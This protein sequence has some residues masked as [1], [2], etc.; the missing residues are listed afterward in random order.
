[1]DNL[2]AVIKKFGDDVVRLSK[3]NL[4]SN[5]YGRHKK[6]NTTKTLSNS[7][8]HQISDNTISF[9]FED[10]GINIDRGV[11]GNKRRI[12]PRWNK[13]IFLPRSSGYKDKMPP[14]RQIQRWVARKGISHKGSIESFSF[15]VTRKIQLYGTAPKL[16]FT[17]AFE[18]EYK[19]LLAAIEPA[20]GEDIEDKLED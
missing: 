17:D 8:K 18:P 10:Y 1:M 20:I 14:P 3:K 11:M 2:K 5:P 12:L 13:S 4:A 15:A 19:E 16:F 7:I 6:I 9:F